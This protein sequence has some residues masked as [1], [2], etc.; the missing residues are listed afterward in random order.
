MKGL[1]GDSGLTGSL[2]LPFLG[3]DCRGLFEDGTGFVRCNDRYA[4]RL[5]L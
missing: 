3:R 4:G 2:G 5:T 1:L